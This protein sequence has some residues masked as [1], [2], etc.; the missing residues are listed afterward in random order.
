MTTKCA[1]RRAMLGS[2]CLTALLASGQALAQDVPVEP[3]PEP[4]AVPA[5]EAAPP[6]DAQTQDEAAAGSD[7]DIVVTARRRSELLQDVPIAVTAYSGEQLD[8]QGSLDI[9]DVGDT[10]PNVTLEVSRG[11]NSTLTAFI[12]GVG[13]QDP[14]AGFEQG[15]GI[16]LDD[17]YL[18]R[19]QGAVLDIY[20]VERIEVLR[21]PQGTLYGRNT[22][23]GAIKYVTRRLAD[24]PTASVRANIGT[25]KQ[26]DVIISASTPIVEGL[27]IGAA[28]AR[29]SRGGFGKNLTTGKDN[30]DKDVIAGRG[31]LELE[32]AEN[33][34][35]RLSGD[36]T[37]DNSNPR[38]GHRLIPGLQSGAPVLDDVFDT[39]GG[40]EDPTQQVKGG[41][42]AFHGEI[43]LSD[44]LKLRSITAYRKDTSFSPIDFDT[45]PAIDFD[46]PAIY[47]NKQFSQEVQALVDTGPLSGLLGAYY[48]KA[49]AFTAFDVRL[50]TT[51]AGFAALTQGDVDT[52]TWALF[53]DFTYDLSDQLSL[54]LGGRY[55]SDNRHSVV[56]RQ[57][58]LG[59]GSPLFGGAGIPFLAP[60]SDYEGERTDKAFTPRA[61]VSYKPN[62]DHN[63][64]ASYSRG[65]K[66]GG[67][68]PRGL[69]SACVGPTGAPCTDAEEF[70]FMAFEPET[71]D[72]YE[73]GWKGSTL[74]RRLQWALA[75]FRADYQDVQVPGS[76]GAIIDG[77]PTFIGV[78]TNAGKARFKGVELETTAQLGED[79][80]AAGDRLRAAVTVGYLDAKY[81]EF[82]TTT[83]FDPETGAPTPGGRAIPVDAADFYKI[84][85]TPKWTWSG[86]LDYDVPVGGGRLNANTTLS[87][88]SKSQ[89]FEWRNPVLDQGGFA[90]WDANLVWRSPGN[91]YT[92]GLHGKNLADKRYITGGYNF[93]SQNL[94][95][96][97]FVG[98]NLPPFTVPYGTPGLEP[99]LG[100][101]GVL[102]GFYG[103][104]R[105]VFISIGAKF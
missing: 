7:Q 83:I 88:R 66:G 12:R 42:L 59:G 80:A 76:F 65:F 64:Y 45:L 47:R 46:V 35:F 55:T 40:L 20:D 33:V 38:G 87:Y 84:Q 13:Q 39:R 18:N 22:I 92:I 31:S 74:G 6:A 4:Q 61:S 86:S 100:R 97:E 23:G 28:V 105:Q 56:F 19:P 44:W 52:K 30:Y 104:P 77:T 16:Y 89:Q 68:D 43:G 11:T 1:L 26:F 21:G 101:E 8:R 75:V 32:P 78:T 96:G 103:N 98:D 53:G 58:Y 2:I 63:F 73:L 54:S 81:R 10:T 71:V 27:N 91:R 25:Y 79:L 15:V 90:L 69:N 5:D 14:V 57:R 50:F 93:M 62:G 60:Q 48:L 49:D 70:E 29:L 36:Y 67:F 51:F 82:L 72:S 95:T 37:W 9:T 85:N 17:V 34:F 24:I 94:L 3:A 99:S 41:G 102:T